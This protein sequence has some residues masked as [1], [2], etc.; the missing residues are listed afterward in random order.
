M[1]AQ[2]LEELRAALEQAKEKCR[3]L[4]HPSGKHHDG[5]EEALRDMRRLRALVIDWEAS[6]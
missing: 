5:W 2:S 6:R 4:W 3:E 1:S